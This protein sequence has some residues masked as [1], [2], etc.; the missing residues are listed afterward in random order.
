VSFKGNI[1]LE[2]TDKREK[3]REGKEE[4]E[5]QRWEREYS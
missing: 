5:V 3:N 4:E 1:I 2:F